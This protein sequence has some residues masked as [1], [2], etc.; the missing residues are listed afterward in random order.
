MSQRAPH[1]GMTSTYTQER[2]FIESL[3]T[4]PGIT[5]MRRY[6]QALLKGER[7]PGLGR[8]LLSLY[9]L[10]AGLGLCLVALYPSWLR[11]GFAPMQASLAT[12]WPWLYGIYHL[13]DERLPLDAGWWQGLM[14]LLALLVQALLWRWSVRAARYQD[15]AAQGILLGSIVGWAALFVV[16]MLLA[17]LGSSLLASDI[18]HSSLYGRLIVLYAVNPYLVSPQ[19]FP[20][21]VAVMGLG[22]HLTP[23]A[24]YGP[25]WL[26]INLLLTLVAREHVGW[27]VL[28]L[29]LLGSVTYF[30]TIALL[31]Q[32]TKHLKPEWRISAVLL[33][34]WNPLVLAL[35]IAQMHV[36]I[37]VICLLCV[38]LW[39]WLRGAL[40]VGWLFLLLAMLMYPPCVVLLP[41]CAGFFIR[42]NALR[43]ASRWRRLGQWTL[44]C[45]LSLFA[46]GLTYLP[47]W[48]GWGGGGLLQ[49]GQMI[50]WSPEAHASLEA[51]LLALIR[52]HPGWVADMWQPSWWVVG[53]LVVMACFLGFS[54][55]LAQTLELLA[56]CAAWLLLLL[57]Y[58]HPVYRSASLLLPLVLLLCTGSWRSLALLLLLQIGALAT[59]DYGL[60]QPGWELAGLLGICLPFLL[61]G[62]GL[63]I[64]AAWRM[65]RA[66]SVPEEPV[67]PRRGLS[68]FSSRLSRPGWLSRPSL[69][70]FKR[71]VT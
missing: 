13:L 32:L 67:K 31:W 12:L 64:C 54:L 14:F 17:P 35:G 41:L 4:T 28:G 37:V 46:L 5:R 61:W 34:A 39:C 27:Q 58:L 26:D 44:L 70:G 45:V 51:G 68:R 1:R 59:Y 38:V 57:A 43:H 63:C 36:E 29:R 9:G 22:G 50:F 21:D 69:R 7:P 30:L 16:L 18:L 60:Q 53:E 10:G 33:Y 23:A 49:Q 8:W 2:E 66:R 15:R 65:A 11:L 55:W 62:W 71:N 47:Y 24:A 56:F 20:Q 48:Q 3:P 19:M 52:G 6:A 40:L 42:E 25:A